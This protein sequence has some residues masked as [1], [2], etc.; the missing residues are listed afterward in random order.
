MPAVGIRVSP[1]VHPDQPGRIEQL[2]ALLLNPSPLRPNCRSDERLFKWIGVNTPPS[3]VIAN[4][5]IRFLAD[6]ASRSSLRDTTNYG[7]G[8]RKFH[9]FCD[10]FSIPETDRL[11]AS[12]PL[13]HSFVLWAVADPDPMEP[14]FADGTPFE[15]VSVSVARKYLS[16]VRAWHI[17]QG[18]PAPLNAN[19]HDRINWSLRGLANIQRH[20]RTRP[21]RPP[22]TLRMLTALKLT[23]VLSDS[24]DACVWAAASCAFWGLMR[25]GEVSVKSRANFC[26]DKHLTRADVKTGVDLDGK[27]YA[28]LD[29]PSAK[30]AGPG[31]I[32]EVFLT[33]QGDSCPIRALDNLRQ[34]V[35]AES[36]DPLFSWR[37]KNG[38]IRP[39]VR[40]A[41]LQR[42]NSILAA[43]GWGTSFGHSFRIGGASF[44]LAQ[45]VQPEI[46]RL[47]GRWKSLAYEVYIRAF[48]QVA[49]RHIGNLES[50]ASSSARVG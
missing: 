15:P 44:F 28:R 13:L 11:P 42:I 40:D 41:A 49:S 22:I 45:G 8:L 9:L 18:W 14:I 50:A 2:G 7:A 36:T 46:V 30:T 17:T 4:P 39:L 29:L 19:D 5:I 6:Q 1:H 10:I 47:A 48:E 3:A 32:Q 38:D 33:A 27:F 43:W 34:V 26:G 25:F 20:K 23:L 24:F 35:P 12:F 16:A 21:P 31:E 37:D